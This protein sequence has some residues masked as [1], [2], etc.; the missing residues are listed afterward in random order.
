V[1][2]NV[3]FKKAVETKVNKF[4]AETKP[5]V[6]R[7]SVVE[8]SDAVLTYPTVPRPITVDTIVVMFVPPGPNAVEKEESAVSMLEVRD[9]VLTYPAE[10]NPVTVEVMEVL[11]KG[12]ER[13][14]AV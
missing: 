9:N 13:N 11:R 4:G 7:P 5:E 1:D 14:P 10:P 3:V 8:T 6:C 2:A 12:V